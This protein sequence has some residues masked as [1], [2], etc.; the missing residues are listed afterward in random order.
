MMKNIPLRPSFFCLSLFLL[1]NIPVSNAQLEKN[2]RTGEFMVQLKGGQTIKDFKELHPE[3]EVLEVVSE[4]WKIYLVGF[5]ETV[6]NEK[7]A[8]EH[9]SKSKVISTF[10]RNHKVQLRSAYP[11]DTSFGTMWGLHN[12]GQS[13]GTVDADID[14]PEAWDI[15]TGGLTSSGDT[16]VVAVIDGGFQL[17]HQ[18]GNYWRNYGE[19][20]GNGIDDDG[21]GYIDDEYGWNAYNNNGSIGV[22]QHGTHVAGTIGAKGNNT[23][24]VTGVNWN[25]K[26]MAVQGSS[27][28]EATVVRAYSYVF[29]QRKLYDQTNGQKGAF[30]VSTNASFGVDYAD[31]ADFPLWCA[32]YD[33]LGTLGIL[34]CGATANLNINIDNTGDVPTACASNFMVSVTNTTRFD[35]KNSGAAYGLTTIDLGA[36]GTQILST[37]PTNGYSSLTG[38]SMATPHVAG[39][40]ALMWAAACPDLMLE[41]KNNP[42]A[43]AL[44]MKQFMLDNVDPISALQGITVSGGRLNAHK[45]LLAVLSYC[46][47]APMPLANGDTLCKGNTAELIASSGVVDVVVHWF[48]S[49][50]GSPIYIGDTLITP[51]LI[52]NTTYYA[53]NYDINQGTYSNKVSVIAHVVNPIQA[54]AGDTIIEIPNGMA[55]LWVNGSGTYSWSP[56]T[57]L[58]NPN[59]ANPEASPLLTTTYIATVTDNEGCVGTDSITVTVIDATSIRENSISPGVKVFPNPFKEDVTFNFSSNFSAGDK[60]RLSVYDI[61][62]KQVVKTEDIT[63]NNYILNR[64][65]L[66]TGIYYYILT[67]GK[68][69]T[70]M[71]D[72]LII[73]D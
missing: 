54:I 5:N 12:T 27:G 30:V 34:S 50:N 29:D 10:Q 33:S 71:R 52:Q 48:D 72:K 22:D 40:I 25:T 26:V 17:S 44:M 4:S 57:G 11:D 39:N 56:S 15:T 41:Y 3:Y 38:T 53:S 73:V 18:D 42:G 51:A 31:P 37:V 21:N 2:Y 6:M 43:V 16:I 14:A 69:N 60:V 66:S 1:F 36:P 58:N 63:G 64:K 59:I 67:F 8:M 70:E 61:M 9:F 13:G 62:G 46:N 7:R 20:P 47:S 19:I 23:Q 24:G 65:G 28:N 55:Q 45:S 32:I 49:P 35:G 68:L